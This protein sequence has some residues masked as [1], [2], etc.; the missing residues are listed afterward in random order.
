M[1]SGIKTKYDFRINSTDFVIFA[2]QIRIG[3]LRF[4]FHRD[5]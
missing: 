2:V 1:N 3:L 5:E 4:D